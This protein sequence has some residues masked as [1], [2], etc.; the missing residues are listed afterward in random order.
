MIRNSI[1]MLTHEDRLTHV[2][3]SIHIQWIP[4]HIGIPGNS[5]A[6]LEAKRGSTFPQTSV[7]VDLATAKA[8]IRRT[9]Q[10]EFRTRYTRD[11]TH[12]ATHR[13]LTGDTN[14]QAH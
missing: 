12:S 2:D 8:L 13:T 4:A 11:P 5:Q 10:E 1:H 9:G 14:P 7:P 3:P 6:D